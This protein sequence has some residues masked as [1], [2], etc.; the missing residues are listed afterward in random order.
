MDY[1]DDFDVRNEE[2]PASLASR[3]ALRK[4]NDPRWDDP[5]LSEVEAEEALLE[6]DA[7]EEEEV[8]AIYGD[9]FQEWN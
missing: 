8:R 5:E 9:P 7:E 1:D 4:R 3:W 6:Y 2:G